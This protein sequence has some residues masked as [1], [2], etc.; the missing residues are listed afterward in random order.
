MVVDEFGVYV[1]WRHELEM[2]P[3][4]PPKEPHAFPYPLRWKGGT[5]DMPVIHVEEIDG[6]HREYA[7]MVVD[8][9]F[10]RVSL[11]P[12]RAEAMQSGNNARATALSLVIASINAAERALETMKEVL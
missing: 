6:R 8:A 12:I 11:A 10:V 7:A 5:N 4:A 9:Q 2:L 3:N 1:I